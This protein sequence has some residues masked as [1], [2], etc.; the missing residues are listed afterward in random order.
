MSPESTTGR[1]LAA[2]VGAFVLSGMIWI[3]VIILV[4]SSV[5]GSEDGTET[6][7]QGSP[8]RL[9]PEKSAD[10]AT[11]APPAATAVRKP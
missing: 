5:K 10:K 6:R 9:A 2:Y 4:R 11:G 8:V 3:G 7:S 1:K